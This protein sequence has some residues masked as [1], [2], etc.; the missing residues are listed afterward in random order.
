M[1]TEQQ[2]SRACL[3]TKQHLKIRSRPAAPFHNFE[4]P[5]KVSIQKKLSKFAIII[6][7]SS[8]IFLNVF[9][10][11][12]CFTF[13]SV[14]FGQA[15]V[16]A[17][18]SRECP[19]PFLLFFFFRAHFLSP[20]WWFYCLCLCFFLSSF[21]SSIHFLKLIFLRWICFLCYALDSEFLFINSSLDW[22]RWW[23]RAHGWRR[24]RTR[25]VT[26]ACQGR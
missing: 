25:P 19:K 17:M 20:S 12:I 24:Q 2:T 6:E 11:F 13:V 23:R 10:L 18:Y 15:F 3:L 22:C 26:H 14:A 9:P 5:S 16:S 7:D 4:E 1:R 8:I 21:S